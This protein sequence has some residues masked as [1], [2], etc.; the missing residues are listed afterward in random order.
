[1]KQLSATADKWY[2]I[3]ILSTIY[4]KTIIEH[5][6]HNQLILW[7]VCSSIV[8]Q[9][10]VDSMFR[11]CLSVD[12]KLYVQIVS[13]RLL[14]LV[15]SSVIY[16][17]FVIC[18]FFLSNTVP[19]LLV[20]SRFKYSLSLDFWKVCLNNIISWSWTAYTNNVDQLIVMWMFNYRFS[21]DC[22]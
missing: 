15:C 13:I 1:M 9:F 14:C 17:P 22:W 6:H 7:I 3:F 16:E 12:G 2:L 18:F 8:Y 20:N 10:I 5:S 11:Y 4:W 19:Q 21:I